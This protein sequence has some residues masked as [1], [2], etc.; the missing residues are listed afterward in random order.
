MK[1]ILTILA[2]SVLVS[3][4]DDWPRWMGE[5]A[6]GYWREEGVRKDLPEG[7][8]PVKWR[9]PVGWGYG[10]PAVVGDSVVLGD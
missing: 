7:G 10:G 8:A 6:D 5:K 9:V 3:S 2:A 4:A 1:K